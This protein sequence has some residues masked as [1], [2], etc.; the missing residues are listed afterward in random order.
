MADIAAIFHWPPST[1]WPMS[2]TELARW[3]H[4]ALLRSGAL[5]NE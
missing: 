2:L 3:R 5:Q 4:K 1:C